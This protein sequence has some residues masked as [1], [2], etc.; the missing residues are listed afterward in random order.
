M[1]MPESWES[2][3]VIIIG[4]GPAGATAAIVLARAGLRV[5]ILEKTTFPRFH[6]G[7]S[8]LPASMP[9]LI[10]TGFYKKLDSGKYIRKY[11]AR[12]VDYRTDDEVYFGFDDSLRPE[13]PMAFEVQRAQFDKDPGCENSGLCHEYDELSC[14]WNFGG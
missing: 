8:L 3:D 5:V 10:E 2:C 1:D 13:F 14:A 6:I 9:H 7:E 12:F 4:G 11:G